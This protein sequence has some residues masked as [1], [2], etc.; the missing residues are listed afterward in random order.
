LG[1]GVGWNPVEYEGLGRDFHLRGRLVEEQIEVLRL[2]WRQEVVAYHGQYHTI[3]EAGLN[4]LPVRRSIPIWTGG[5]ADVLLRRTA[6]LAEAAMAEPGRNA[7]RHQH[8]GGRLHLLAR[9]SRG[10]PPL[11]GGC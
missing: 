11:Q 10:H 7:C 5:R 1:V 4:P 2:L 3:S 6:R 9:A 8:H